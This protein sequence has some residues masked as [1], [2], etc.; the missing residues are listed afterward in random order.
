[1]RVR[2]NMKLGDWLIVIF[3]LLIKKGGIKNDCI[4]IS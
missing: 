1:M 3:S 2:K 4:R